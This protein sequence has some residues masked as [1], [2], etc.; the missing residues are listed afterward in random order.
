VRGLEFFV[1]G[2]IIRTVAV[3]PTFPTVGVLAIIVLIRT[4]LSTT[5]E[6]ELAGRG[7]WQRG[8]ATKT[9]VRHTRPRGIP[10]R[11]ERLRTT[12]QYIFA[13]VWFA[14]SSSS[15]TGPGLIAVSPR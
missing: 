1:A 15:V 13:G 5:L 11:M 6:L 14:I 10:S 8:R 12:W 4:F 9:Y 2:H 7:P 3:D